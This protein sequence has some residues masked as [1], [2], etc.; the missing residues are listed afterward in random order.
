MPNEQNEEK[1][2]LLISYRN[3]EKLHNMMNPISGK[4]RTAIDF[5]HALAQDMDPMD[6]YIGAKSLSMT[7]EKILFDKGK[8]D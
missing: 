1:L 2:R 3:A 5:F 4:A 8:N 7:L 6:A